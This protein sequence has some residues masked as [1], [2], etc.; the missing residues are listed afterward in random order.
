MK[1]AL[2]KAIERQNF[3][4]AEMNAVAGRI[5]DGEAT[6]AQIGALLTALRMKGEVVDE[7]VGAAQAMRARMLQVTFDAPALLDTCGTGGDGSGSVNVS[8]LASFIVA[9][10]GVPVAKHGNRAL[11]SRSGSHDVIE[12]LGIDPAPGPDLAAR[13]LREV[14]ICFMFAPVFHAAT[15]HAAAPRRELGFRTMF[16]LLGPLT[17]PAGA[18][19]HVNGVF[20]ADRCEFL[21]RA[22]AQLGSRRALV[23]HGAGGLDEFA[24]SGSTCVA[25]LGVDGAIRVYEVSPRDFGLEPADPAGLK[26][27][28]PVLNASLLRESL[29]GGGASASR[30]VALMTAGAGLYVAGAAESLRAGVERA[31]EALDSG[32]AAAVLERLKSVAPGGLA[33]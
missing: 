3:S 25:E 23:V 12:A 28:D 26:G 31:R 11:S 8:T 9:A 14:G 32:K 6:P 16:N 7:V 1:E 13:C 4:A 33:K 5:M 20:A 22:H 18:R 29:F 24:P 17:N 15:R 19:H 10:C 27:G 30:L 2:A 21:A